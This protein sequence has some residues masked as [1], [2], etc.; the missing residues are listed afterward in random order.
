MSSSRFNL[1][2]IAVG[3]LML[4]ASVVRAAVSVQGPPEVV[5]IE[6]EN[7]SIEDV[8]RALGEAYGL[9]YTSNIPLQKK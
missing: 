1:L 5:R 9:T 7:V 6:A 2:T 8:L 4:T 3:F